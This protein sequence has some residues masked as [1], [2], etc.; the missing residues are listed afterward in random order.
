MKRAIHVVLIA[1]LGATTAACVTTE[2]PP[3]P[4]PQG[5][6]ACD[7]Y[8][9][10]VGNRWVYD[11]PQGEQLAVTIVGQHDGFFQDDKQGSL[12]CD[13]LGLQ[14][15]KRYLLQ[16]PVEMGHQWSNVVSVGTTE[17]SEV[18][19]VGGSIQTPAGQFDNTVT[20]LAKSRIDADKTL[21]IERTFAPHVGIV[22]LET[23]LLTNGQEIPQIAISL[24]SFHP[25]PV[26]SPSTP[27]PSATPSTSASP[28][29][30]GEIGF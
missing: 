2:K 18:T 10:A 4:K 7:Y 16:S 29:S 22:K 12:R 5:P 26:S 17:H 6:L 19:A 20:V 14:D 23:R 27:T 28:G 21:I 8:P 9:L 24:R 13:S 3:P 1:L 25:A 30:G 11:G 15:G